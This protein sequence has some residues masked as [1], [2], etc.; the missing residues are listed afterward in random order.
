MYSY[1]SFNMRCRSLGLEINDIHTYETFVSI[2][3]DRNGLISFDDFK[4]WWFAGQEA[5]KNGGFVKRIFV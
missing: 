4:E 5:N 1:T 3:R 2:D